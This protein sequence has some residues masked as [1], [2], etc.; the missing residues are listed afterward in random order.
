MHCL[1]PYLVVLLSVAAP[2]CARSVAA[3][4]AVRH[5]SPVT[6]ELV[7][8][9]D[10]QIWVVFQASDENHWFGSNGQ[11]VYRHDGKTLVRFTTEHGLVGDHIRGIQ[12]DRAGNIYIATEPAGISR[13]DGRGFTTLKAADPARCEWKLGP[14]DLW[15]SCGQ[16]TGAVYRYDGEMLH[17]LTLPK[18]QA[19]EEHNA[20]HPRSL[21][22]NANYSPYDVYTIFKDSKGYVWFGTAVLGACR[23]DGTSHA[24][25]DKPGLELGSFGVRAIIE[26]KDGRFWFSS[27]RNRYAVDSAE[28]AERGTSALNHRLE[29]GF[30]SEGLSVFNTALV[31]RN[32]DL[33]LT[34]L[35]AGVWRHGGESMTHYPVTHDGASIWVFSVYC[36]R[37]QVLWLG[38]QE[39]GVYRFNGKAFERVRFSG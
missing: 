39:H 14:Q 1:R 19:G 36:D 38:T 9:L 31:D 25:I 6:G 33:W 10:N 17:R 15:F 32:A 11:G 27:T 20:R 37:E 29:Q 35:G 30:D 3:Q 2:S 16:N 28:A 12:E 24:W 8:E 7:D 4:D 22:P 5:A 18:T 13:F 34:T 26:D 23:F 21:F